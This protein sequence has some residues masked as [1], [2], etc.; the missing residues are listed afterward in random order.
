MKKGKNLIK[1]IGLG[2][3]LKL[4]LLIPSSTRMPDVD[5]NSGAQQ[6]LKNSY[7][8][9]NHEKGK[10]IPTNQYNYDSFTKPL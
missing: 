4:S 3:F 6:T 7:T 2:A 8:S 10:D 5:Y 9:I 1:A